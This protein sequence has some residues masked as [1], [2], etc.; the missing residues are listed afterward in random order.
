VGELSTFPPYAKAGGISSC[1]PNVKAV[2]P[3]IDA[4]VGISLDRA[5][6]DSRN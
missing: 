1:S 6:E 2:R 4:D 3:D 5:S